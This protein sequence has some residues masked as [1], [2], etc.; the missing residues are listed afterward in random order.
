MRNVLTTER[1]YFWIQIIHLGKRN[2]QLKIY[3]VA[4]VADHI[5]TKRSYEF[6]IF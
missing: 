5:I 6:F 4:M 1:E 3:Y 2:F